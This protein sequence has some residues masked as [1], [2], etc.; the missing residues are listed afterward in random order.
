MGEDV[1]DDLGEVGGGNRNQNVLYKKYIFNL[2]RRS[3]EN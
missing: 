3:D 1:G 2:K